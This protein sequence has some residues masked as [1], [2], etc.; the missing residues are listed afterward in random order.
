MAGGFLGRDA[1]VGVEQQVHLGGGQPVQRALQ[2]C[3]LSRMGRHDEHTGAGCL[4]LRSG[5][6]RG[7]IVHD[8]HLGDLGDGPDRLHRRGHAVAL[9]AGGHK[10][11][12]VFVRHGS[13]G[14]RSEAPD[15]IP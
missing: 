8:D 9:V 14:R 5:P 11:Q 2:R 4:G 1:E 7:A 10:G 3:P 13:S 15:L 6:I 12:D